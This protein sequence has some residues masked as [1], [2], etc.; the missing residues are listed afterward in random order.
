VHIQEVVVGN[1]PYEAQNGLRVGP[2]VHHLTIR[3]TALSLVAP[4]KVHFRYKLDGVDADWREVVNERNVQYSNLPPG[5]YHFRVLACNNSDMWNEQGASLNFTVFAAVVPDELVPR[6]MR[7][8]CSDIVVDGTQIPR[9][10]TGI[11]VQHAHGR[12]NKRAH[13]HLPATCTTRCFRVSRRCCRNFKLRFLRYRRVRSTLATHWNKLSIRHLR[14]LARVATQ[15]RGCAI[16]R[17]RRTILRKPF[18]RLEKNWRQ[19]NTASIPL[20]FGCSWKAHHEISTRFCET[21][22]PSRG[23]GPAQCVQARGGTQHRSRNL[24]RREVS[25]VTRSRRRKRHKPRCCQRTCGPLRL[26]RYE[27]MSVPCR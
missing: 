26:A 21:K 25:P 6:A 11:P 19:R 12:A 13:A 23:R 14:P 22:L 17:S 4:E 1:K 7:L 8:E 16:P 10:A 20:C 5:K 24:L 27:G 3:Y 9:E 15:V 18:G 2:G